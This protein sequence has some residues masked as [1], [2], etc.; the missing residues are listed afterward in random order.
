[1]YSSPVIFLFLKLDLFPSVENFSSADGH[2]GQMPWE[3]LQIF[4]H[5]SDILV[6]F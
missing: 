3:I 2:A 1:M 6:F 5:Q 4:N